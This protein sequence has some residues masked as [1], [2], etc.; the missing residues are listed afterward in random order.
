[1]ISLRE[2]FEEAVLQCIQACFAEVIPEIL[3]FTLTAIVVLAIW[4]HGRFGK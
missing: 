1:M 4:H 2:T 3:R